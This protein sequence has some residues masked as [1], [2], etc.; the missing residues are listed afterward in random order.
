VSA[1][2]PPARRHSNEAN[3]APGMEG[4]HHRAW[5]LTGTHSQAYARHFPAAL[6]ARVAEVAM[7]GYRPKGRHPGGRPSIGLA[8]LRPLGVPRYGGGAKC[9]PIGIHVLLLQSSALRLEVGSGSLSV[10]QLPQYYGRSST[11]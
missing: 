9:E 6:R 11:T 4:R 1:S 3:M 7:A 10:Q 2:L 8:R 5:G